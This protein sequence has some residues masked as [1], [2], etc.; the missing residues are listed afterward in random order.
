MLNHIKYH[1]YMILYH[2]IILFYIINS[3]ERVAPATPMHSPA[4]TV[5]FDCPLHHAQAV[6]FNLKAYKQYHIMS[7]LNHIP[8]SALWFRAIATDLEIA[9]QR[10]CKAP[11]KSP[12]DID[13]QNET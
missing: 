4:G 8:S 13:F 7:Y 9:S 6:T 1:V 3:F 11:T 5:S 12:V 10:H 2:I